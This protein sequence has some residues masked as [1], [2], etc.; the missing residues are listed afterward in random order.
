MFPK[1]ILRNK[2]KVFEGTLNLKKVIFQHHLTLEEAK[3]V[4]SNDKA[5]IE[6]NII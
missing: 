1:S 2:G 5:K 6:I 3:W 4:V